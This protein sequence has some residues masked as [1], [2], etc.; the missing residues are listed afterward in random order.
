MKNK[1]TNSETLTK[2][3]KP[4][5]VSYGVVAVDD[6]ETCDDKLPAGASSTASVNLSNDKKKNENPKSGIECY[7]HSSSRNS[8]VESS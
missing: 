5:M 1:Q 6:R 3:I 4:E 2:T 8:L 7:T